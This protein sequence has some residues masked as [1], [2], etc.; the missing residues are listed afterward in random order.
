MDVRLKRRAKR[1]IYSGAQQI[2]WSHLNG[3]KQMIFQQKKLKGGSRQPQASTTD[4]WDKTAHEVK[5]VEN[6]TF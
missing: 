1:R 5:I 2:M 3:E 6:D 4:M